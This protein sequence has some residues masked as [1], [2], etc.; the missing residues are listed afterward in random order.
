[1]R[2]PL[3][4]WRRMPCCANEFA[5]CC[6]RIFSN[7]HKTAI[8]DGVLVVI[9]SFASSGLKEEPLRRVFFC[10]GFFLVVCACLSMGCEEPETPKAC[11]TTADCV[12]GEVCKNKLCGA[13]AA[14][15]ECLAGNICADG[16]C[17]LG[18][19][20]DAQCAGKSKCVD[21]LC[22]GGCVQTS[23]CPSGQVCESNEC[24]PG[25]ATRADCKDPLYCNQKTGLCV[26]CAKDEHC[27]DG[28]V[29]SLAGTCE[30]PKN[31][32]CETNK[33]VDLQSDANHCGTCGVV[34]DLGVCGNGVCQLAA[35]VVALGGLHSC[36]L[37]KTGELRC[38]GDN[39]L[40]ALG[41]G[42][43]TNRTK[44]N[45]VTV[46]TS[47]QTFTLQG[48]ES[49]QGYSS[50]CVLR[51]D[52]GLKC[53]GANQYGQLGNGSVLPS[54]SP[55]NVK[56]VVDV[57]AIVSGKGIDYNGTPAG[58]HRCVLLKASGGSVKCWGSN[59]FGELGD[60]TVDQRN[61][62]VAVLNLQNVAQV[63][64]GGAH[65]CALLYNGKVECWGDNTYGQLG[66]GNTNPTK[67]PI[68]VKGVN[69]AKAIAVGVFHSCA[70]L[71]TSDVVCWG[72]NDDGQVGQSERKD[73]KEPFTI[74]G[75][76]D[77]ISITAGRFQTCALSKD[78]T[79]TCW[80]RNINGTMGLGSLTDRVYEPTPLTLKPLAA[81]S[82]GYGH[83]CGILQPNGALY[84]WGGNDY[85]QLG[86][87]TTGSVGTPTP[88][89]EN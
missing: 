34:C 16:T 63:A 48:H 74:K 10:C 86:T 38:W 66:T 87:G 46:A 82:I 49:K 56:N 11:R 28:E 25:C 18:C 45:P 6:A 40:G 8:L 23:D 36:A 9:R 50:T 26:T 65:T 7:R 17:R 24:V 32:Q 42:T 20:T 39:Q 67:A 2:N 31:R 4:A 57:Q 88:V 27:P 21:T 3:Q 76:K 37:T 69:T 33:C 53:W 70:L 5:I 44:P 29:C 84:C 35:D 15:G 43:D 60:G 52:G 58:F 77:T 13:C 78:G 12:G 64:A 41:D 61:E 71:E 80:G 19:R 79:A 22:V 1:M 81:L 62:P 72:R 51:R 75:L 68:D 47:V 59:S 14:D 54:R 73:Q 83:A 85:G 30:C 55:V 89:P